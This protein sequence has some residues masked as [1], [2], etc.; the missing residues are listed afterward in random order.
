LCYALK[1]CLDN[2]L[3]PVLQDDPGNAYGR[4]TDY[5]EPF[6]DEAQERSIMARSGALEV[7]ENDLEWAANRAGLFGDDWTSLAGEIKAIFLR[8]FV[9]RESVSTDIQRKID[10]L[11]LPP[12]YSSL[13]VRRGAKNRQFKDYGALS[14]KE[15]VRRAEEMLR[16]QGVKDV[17]VMTDDYR[18]IEEIRASTSLNIF[19]L[20][21]ES[22]LGSDTEV[23]NAPGHTLDLLTEIVGA[24]NAE[25]HF[26]TVRSRVS[27]VVRL[28]RDDRNC[29]HVFE[30]G[31]TQYT[32]L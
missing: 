32:A 15:I 17:F 26:Q 7:V 29:H 13:H 12:G 23:R 30:E 18:V 4:W 3:Y 22:Y 25:A 27:K 16:R 14:D 24:L 20:C 19:T 5:F 28:L 2:D 8:I 10:R 9:L 11:R 1:Y 21:R 31:Y 6:W